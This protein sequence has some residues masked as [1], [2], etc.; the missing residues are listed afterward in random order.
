MDAARIWE[1][2]GAQTTSSS[3]LHR[4][5]KLPAVDGL[6]V[7]HVPKD[8]QAFRNDGVAAHLHQVEAGRRD[9]VAGAEE[10][11]DFAADVAA[12]SVELLCKVLGEGEERGEGTSLCLAG[13]GTRRGLD[14]PR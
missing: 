5:E 14:M 2:R 7:R 3:Y 12:V 4:G 10:G 8:V 9:D 1:G 6:E 13:W 11:A